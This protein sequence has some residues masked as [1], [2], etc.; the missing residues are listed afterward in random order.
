MATTAAELIDQIQSTLKDHIEANNQRMAEVEKFGEAG[1]EVKEKV[2]RV[3]DEL[4]TLMAQV[5]EIATTIAR[6]KSGGGD[7]IQR[8]TPGFD[9]VRE[10]KYERALADAKNN[11]DILRKEALGGLSR[12]F[13]SLITSNPDTSGGTLIIPERTGIVVPFS[14]PAFDVLNIINVGTT[15]SNSVEYVRITAETNN[16][17]VVAESTQTEDEDTP[18]AATGYKPWSDLEFEPKVATVYTI[19]TLIAV[20]NQAFQDAGQLRGII[21]DFGVWA[22]RSVLANAVINGSGS[23]EIEG[24]DTVVAGD[25]VTFSAAVLTDAGIIETARK[26]LTQL[27]TTGRVR[28]NAF[29]FNPAD[30]ETLDLVR[31]DKNFGN[32]ATAAGVMTLFGI[33]VVT[34]EN[35]AVGHAYVGAFNPWYRLWM[36]MSANIE[37]TPSHKDWFERNLIALRFE[38]RAAGGLTMEKAIVKFETA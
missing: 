17:A 12:R 38:E 20:T 3:S 33:P 1:A 15:D 24:F 35:V 28:P 16:A 29:L 4:A 37:V 26:A 14:R 34:D 5:T 30:V 36:R 8:V 31:I 19:A 6:P 25:E 21:N 13:K 11:G 22:L 18:S 9:F 2:D 23:G 27:Q 7:D 10:E 32:E